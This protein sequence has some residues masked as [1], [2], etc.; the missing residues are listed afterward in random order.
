[1]AAIPSRRSTTN[2]ILTATWRSRAM[3]PM[4]NSSKGRQGRGVFKVR[5]VR[6][7]A[8]VQNATTKRQQLLTSSQ[9][10]AHPMQPT[11]PLPN[12]R[13]SDPPPPPRRQPPSQPTPWSAAKPLNE[14][15]PTQQPPA[16]RLSQ[17]PAVKPQPKRR[18][19]PPKSQQIPVRNQ[20]PAPYSWSSGPVQGQPMLS[21]E[22]TPMRQPTVPR[23]HQQQQQH[24]KMHMSGPNDSRFGNI[25]GGDTQGQGMAPN[26]TYRASSSHIY[27]V[28]RPPAHSVLPSQTTAG[29]VSQPAAGVSVQDISDGC[30]VCQGQHSNCSCVNMDSIMD[31][32]LA[33]DMLRASQAGPAVV[34]AL[35]QRLQQRIRE[36]TGPR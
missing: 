26:A 30:V 6:L 14:Q 3:M 13:P 16:L 19:R 32:R 18:G 1:M 2:S 27:R 4:K 17:A 35:R 22:T 24:Q 5:S 36:L 29:M 10:T 33:V 20:A 25:D 11:R 9:A 15:L 12:R 31:L 23:Q 28:P 21:T 7:H 8:L 34:Q